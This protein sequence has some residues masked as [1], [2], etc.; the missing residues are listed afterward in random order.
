MNYKNKY[1]N[2]WNENACEKSYLKIHLKTIM[3]RHCSLNFPA[4]DLLSDCRVSDVIVAADKKQ[5]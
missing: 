4:T 2:L 1:K 3:R 5:F